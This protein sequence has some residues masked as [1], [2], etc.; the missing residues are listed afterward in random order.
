MW[1]RYYSAVRVAKCK[2]ASGFF[3]AVFKYMCLKVD[4]RIY[5]VIILQ[6]SN[7]GAVK[8]ELCAPRQTLNIIQYV[9]LYDQGQIL[10]NSLSNE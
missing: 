3:T 4:V 8:D 10:W 6:Q 9:L 1:C 2:R 7:I 5:Q